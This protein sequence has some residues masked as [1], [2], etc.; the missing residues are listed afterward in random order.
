MKIENRK[1]TTKK[2]LEELNSELVFTINKI[3]DDVLNGS[4]IASNEIAEIVDMWTWRVTDNQPCS[5]MYD[6]GTIAFHL[7]DSILNITA[8]TPV[9]RGITNHLNLHIPITTEGPFTVT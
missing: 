8:G 9:T 7:I 3:I 6:R 1:N 5:Q 4:K 2:G